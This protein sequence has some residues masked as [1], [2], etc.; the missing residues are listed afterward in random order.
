MAQ[1]AVKDT[2]PY[3]RF[4]TRPMCGAL[5]AEILGL[6]LSKPLDEGL[7]AELRRAFLDNLVLVIRDQKL[8]E[9]QQIDFTAAFGNEVMRQ[10]TG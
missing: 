1:A 5:G 4:Q 6:D 10:P 9:R 8:T 7:K 3:T 2:R